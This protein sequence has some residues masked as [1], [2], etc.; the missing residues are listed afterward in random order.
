MQVLGGNPLSLCLLVIITPSLIAANPLWS[1][2]QVGGMFTLPLDFWQGLH[3]C[4]SLQH[5][6]LASS[7]P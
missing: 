2:D 7:A 1:L 4:R 6:S 5:T 3:T